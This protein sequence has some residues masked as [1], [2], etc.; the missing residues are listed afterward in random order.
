M[1][2]CTFCRSC[3]F[4]GVTPFP[5][6]ALHK[7][8]EIAF[9]MWIVTFKPFEVRL[10][11]RNYASVDDAIVGYVSKP[12]SQFFL[13][14]CIEGEIL[15]YLHDKARSKIFTC[16]SGGRQS[17]PDE[18]GPCHKYTRLHLACMPPRKK[19]KQFAVHASRAP[20]VVPTGPSTVTMPPRS[21]SES[22]ETSTYAYDVASL[23]NRREVLEILH[24]AESSW[25]SEVVE[26]LLRWGATPPLVRVHE[27]T[28]KPHFREARCTFAHP[29][30][31][32]V[33]NVYLPVGL[34]K[35]KYPE[36]VAHM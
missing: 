34:L 32:L 9:Y 27:V 7:D 2:D 20:S 35:V 36:H 19:Q 15:N 11:G 10:R 29:D 17:P 21:D 12:P 1:C 30:G 14:V 33:P 24:L 3:K 23:G 16:P 13:I 4:Q 25:T 6:L 18:G 26:E 31:A 22:E 5:L 28:Q 8:R